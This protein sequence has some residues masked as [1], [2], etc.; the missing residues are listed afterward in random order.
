MKH[1]QSDI[2]E[3][4]IAFWEKR[5]GEACSHEDARQIVANIA[6]FFDL[7]TEWDRKDQEEGRA[8]P[9]GGPGEAPHQ[10]PPRSKRI[11]YNDTTSRETSP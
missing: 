8:L 6:G 1:Q 2:I 7:L 5:T 10:L 4:T 11:M 3:H 9:V